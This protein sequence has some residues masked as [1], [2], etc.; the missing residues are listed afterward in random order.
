[1]KNFYSFLFSLFLGFSFYAKDQKMILT[2]KVLTPQTATPQELT[3]HKKIG[4]DA[5]FKRD[6]PTLP[7]VIK[8]KYDQW[9]E[10][11]YDAFK[12]QKE[13]FLISAKDEQQNVVGGL[14]L[15]TLWGPE[16]ALNLKEKQKVLYIYLLYVDPCHHRKGIATQ[17]LK[18]LDSLA[19]ITTPA[20]P[21]FVYTYAINTTAQHMYKKGGYS[22]VTDT[23]HPL[24]E[25]SDAARILVGGEECLVAPLAYRK[26]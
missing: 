20:T 14:Y 22:L 21:L 18:C 25:W 6:L 1:M 11:T 2:L 19:Q 16:P 4:S 17:L 7:N 3:A 5:Y 9:F 8:H 24:G 13:D 23:A 10:M 26:N 15:K 12:D